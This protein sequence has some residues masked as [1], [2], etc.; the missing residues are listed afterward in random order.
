MKFFK[1]KNTLFISNIPKDQW[2]KCPIT[3]NIIYKNII[4]ENYMVDLKTNYHF[5]L[6]ARERIK[7]LIDNNSFKEFDFNIESLD[8]IN[9]NTETYSYKKK[10]EEYQKKTGLKEAVICGL[11]NINNIPVSIS[12]MD[13][14]FMG[15]SM[16]SVVGEKITRSIERAIENKIPLIIVSSSGGARMQEGIFSLM[17]MVKT[18]AALEKLNKIKLPYISILTNPT[19]GGVMASFAS[20]GDIILAEPKALIGFAGPRVI[21]STTQQK[22]LPKNFQ[23]SEFLLKKGLIDQ[24]VDR[25]NMK[26]KIYSLLKILYLK[27]S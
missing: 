8:P 23:T 14:R 25:K 15:A 11:G 19:M 3:G 9:F 7:L 20:L 24:I 1:Q 12:I 21:K 22:E 26:N 4:K 13:F 18:S 5:P 17:Q 27:T 10:I 2:I 6:E 16:G